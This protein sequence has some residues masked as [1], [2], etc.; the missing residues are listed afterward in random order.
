MSRPSCARHPAKYG[1]TG[2]IASSGNESG[3]IQKPNWK[4]LP[5][6]RS[7]LAKHPVEDTMTMGSYQQFCLVSMAPE[8]LCT[9]WTIILLREMFAGSTRT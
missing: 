4:T 1:I 9:R 5:S 6:G 3:P 8:I 7:F 2:G